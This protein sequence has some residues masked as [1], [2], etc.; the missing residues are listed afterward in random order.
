MYARRVQV[1]GQAESGRGRAGVSGRIILHS[2][3]GVSRPL[4][5][6]SSPASV[7][8]AAKQQRSS[9][10]FE[11]GRARGRAPRRP[12]IRGSSSRTR[13]R[14]RRQPRRRRHGHDSTNNHQISLGAQLPVLLI[15]APTARQSRPY[16]LRAPAHPPTIHRHARRGR[17]QPLAAHVA[18]VLGRRR[19]LCLLCARQD[20][21]AHRLTEPDCPAAAERRRAQRCRCDSRG[22][23]QD[24]DVGPARRDGRAGVYVCAAC[25]V[26]SCGFL[27]D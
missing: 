4:P 1:G 17:G 7:R 12:A 11:H 20:A 3:G 5:P 25:R 21:R 23:A 15:R 26:G 10:D 19:P 6:A 13:S 9:A 27:D 8:R 14:R 2:V 18:H 16:H 22:Q 24:V